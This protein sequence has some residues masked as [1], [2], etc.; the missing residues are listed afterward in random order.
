MVSPGPVTNVTLGKAVAG[1]CPWNWHLAVLRLALGD[2]QLVV[3]DWLLVMRPEFG[4]YPSSERES[5]GSGKCATRNEGVILSA[6]FARFANAESKDPSLH[7]IRPRRKLTFCLRS[8]RDTI[9]PLLANSR[10]F[11]SVLPLRVLTLLKMTKHRGPAL[12]F[13]RLRFVLRAS[14]MGA[15]GGPSTPA[16]NC[17]APAPRMT[18][19]GRRPTAIANC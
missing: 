4:A 12:R 14:R 18:P 16:R 7:L 17:G 1:S 15:V 11:D 2:W 10:S 9:I 19:V 13:M 6:A 3:D 8:Q 5:F